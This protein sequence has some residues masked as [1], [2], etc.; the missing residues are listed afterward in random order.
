MND[1]ARIALEYLQRQFNISR[2]LSTTSEF[3]EEVKNM[4]GEHADLFN[5]VI[6]MISWLEN[7]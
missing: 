2:K 5:K 1:E 6:Q 7:A 4:H 3:G